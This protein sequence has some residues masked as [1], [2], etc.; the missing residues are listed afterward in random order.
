MRKNI[1]KTDDP[2][3][4]VYI[5]GIRLTLATKT[6]P[7][8]TTWYEGGCKTIKR[9]KELNQKLERKIIKILKKPTKKL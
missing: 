9:A 1:N 8:H 2:K 5:I 3:N 4:D 7:I 6:H